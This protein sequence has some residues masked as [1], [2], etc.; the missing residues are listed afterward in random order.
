MVYVKQV[1]CD[2][3]AMYVALNNLLLL[4]IDLEIYFKSFSMLAFFF[5]KKIVFVKFVKR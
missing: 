1:R 5:T 2:S 4:A 3:H